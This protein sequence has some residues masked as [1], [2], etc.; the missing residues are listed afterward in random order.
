MK[1]FFSRKNKK[2][3]NKSFDSSISIEPSSPISPTSTSTINNNLYTNNGIDKAKSTSENYPNSRIFGFPLP[4]KFEEIPSFVFEAFE[5]LENKYCLEVEGIFRLSPNKEELDKLLEVLEENSSF[6]IHFEDK[7]GKDNG[8][9]I[10]S[11]LLKTYL[12]ELTIPLLTFEQYDMFIAVAKIPDPEPRKEMLKKLVGFL[13][14][15]HYL[16][17]KRLMKFL[18][19]VSSHS[20]INKMTSDN[21]AIVFAPN[22]LKDNGDNYE[23]FE[24]MRHTKYVNHLTQILIDEMEFIFE[25]KKQLILQETLE[26]INQLSN[27]TENDL[28]IMRRRESSVSRR[29]KISINEKRKTLRLMEKVVLAE[30][31]DEKKVDISSTITSNTIQ[32]KRLVPIR[33]T[34]ISPNTSPN[35]SPRKTIISKSPPLVKTN[36]FI[37]KPSHLLLNTKL[38]NDSPE[39][40]SPVLITKMDFMSDKDLLVSEIVKCVKRYLNSYKVF[41][42][43]IGVNIEEESV[44]IIF[45]GLILHNITNCDLIKVIENVTNLSSNNIIHTEF[46]ELPEKLLTHFGKPY[47]IKV[48]YDTLEEYD[49]ALDSCSCVMLIHFLHALTQ[50]FIENHQESGL[51]DQY[52]VDWILNIFPSMA[53]YQYYMMV[54]F[55]LLIRN[56][57]KKNDKETLRKLLKKSPGVPEDDSTTMMTTFSLFEANTIT[58]TE[59]DIEYY[60]DEL[61][62]NYENRAILLSKMMG[63]KMHPFKNQEFKIHKGF[64]YHFGY[65]ITE[66]LLVKQQTKNPLVLFDDF[67]LDNDIGVI[68]KS[69]KFQNDE[70]IIFDA[71]RAQDLEMLKFLCEECDVDVN[72]VNNLGITPCTLVKVLFPK[73]SQIRMKFDKYL[74][75]HNAIT[76]KSKIFNLNDYNWL[77]ILKYLG[78]SYKQLSDLILAIPLLNKEDIWKYLFAS[79]KKN[80]KTSYINLKEWLETNDSYPISWRHFVFLN[81]LFNFN[82]VF[83]LLDLNDQ[84][85]R[86]NT[87]LIPKSTELNVDDGIFLLRHI[88]KHVNIDDSPLLMYNNIKILKKSESSMLK[89]IEEVPILLQKKD[90]LQKFITAMSYSYFKEKFLKEKGNVSLY[91]VHIDDIIYIIGLNTNLIGVNII[92]DRLD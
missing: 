63:G 88:F 90:T 36:S 20:K 65:I 50:F 10:A 42:I 18:N 19:L 72:V 5:Y 45:S 47:T 84:G 6:V 9:L 62:I 15:C 64:N 61:S 86:K 49:L 40:A 74:E 11:A 57:Y 41:G 48:N 30:A 25:E 43:N 26:E 39:V 60:E 55:C 13:P 77:L 29:S 27:Q 76:T 80:I 46:K 70:L 78:Y 56:S 33:K 66:E 8:P 75:S 2:E 7:F 58:A 12:R 34:I 44:E 85:L 79:N 71:I 92:E 3:N 31:D 52:F 83:Y 54:L 35:N 51:D 81:Y 37:R 17:L 32:P 69:R 21:L 22:I 28:E 68:C 82:F 53:Y 73:N 59:E 38:D 14:E 24:L 16:L 89:Y 23:I 67:T 1:K 91:I 87:L 4:K